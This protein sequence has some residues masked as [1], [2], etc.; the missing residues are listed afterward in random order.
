MIETFRLTDDAVVTRAT[1]S[2]DV[3]GW[4]SLSHALLIMNVEEA[5]GTELPLERTYELADVGELVDLLRDAV[6]RT[7]V[8]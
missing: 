2:L 4:D 5:F 6:A 1:T 8:R 7:D 3:D